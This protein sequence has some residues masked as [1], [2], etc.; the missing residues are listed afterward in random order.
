MKYYKFLIIFLLVFLAGCN[1]PLDYANPWDRVIE[2][3]QLQS[4][5]AIYYADLGYNY[6]LEEKYDDAINAYKKSLEYENNIIIKFHLAVGNFNNLNYN[7]GIKI[8]EDLIENSN[9]KLIQDSCVE[10]IVSVYVLQKKYDLALEYLEKSQNID[11]YLL[12]KSQIYNGLGNYII[13]KNYAENSLK[14]EG[15]INAE[16]EIAYAEYKL[17]NYY[18]ANIYFNKYDE[19]NI[20]YLYQEGIK[21][22]YENTSLE[23]A[24]NIEDIRVGFDND[25]QYNITIYYKKLDYYPE[26]EDYF[27]LIRGENVDF[28]DFFITENITYDQL[29]KVTYTF[30]KSY[31]QD[32]KGKTIGVSIFNSYVYN[33]KYIELQ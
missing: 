4:E 32:I 20:K 29:H 33:K 30:H 27:I 17:G 19:S 14:K 16:Y 21:S 12:Y 23:G 10:S 25:G 31:T 22:E 18:N 2:E 5:N 9:E 28:S 15:Y 11:N 6:N 8:C 1:A 7:E 24:I 3:N 13:A 26:T